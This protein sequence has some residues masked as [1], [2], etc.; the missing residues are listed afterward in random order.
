MKMILAIK[1]AKMAECIGSFYRGNGDPFKAYDTRILVQ[2][3]G[4]A[5]T[6]AW[7]R[8]RSIVFP[9]PHVHKMYIGC[10]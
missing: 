10:A 8:P 6:F 1:F 3:S 2:I 7:R 4:S 9:L 5:L